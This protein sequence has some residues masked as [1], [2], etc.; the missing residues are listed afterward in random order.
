MKKIKRAGKKWQTEFQ[1]QD[2][3]DLFDEYGPTRGIYCGAMFSLGWFVEKIFRGQDG[4]PLQLEAFQLVILDT[5]WNKKFPMFLATRGGSKSFMIALYSVLRALLIPGSKVVIV[6]A[7]FRQAKTVFKYIE[8]FY[9][10]SPILR[11]AVAPWGGPKYGSDNASIR[12]GLSTIKAIPL[13]DGDKIRGERATVLIVDEF[14]SV[15]EEIFDIVL[16][17]FVSVQLNPAEKARIARFI[18]RLKELNVQQEILDLISSSQGFGNQVIVSGTPSYKHNHFYKRYQ[19]Y[20]MFINSK[21]D[22][23]ALKAAIEQ[24]ELSTTGKMKTTSA[25]DLEKMAKSH[26]NYAIIQLPY[27]ALPPEFLDEEMIRADRAAF[28]YHRF[29]MEYEAQF[30]DDSDGF[31][32]RS[33]IEDSTPKDNP[34]K[35]ELYGNPRATYVMGLDPARWNDNFGCVVLKITARGK[36]LVYCNAWD[37]TD[38]SKSAQK[39]REICMRFNVSYIAMDKGG[40]GDSVLEWL[41]TKNDTTTDNDIFLPIPDQTENLA[42]K[43]ANGRRIVE[44]VN[45]SPQWISEAAHSVEASIQQRNI[46]YPVTGDDIEIYDQYMRHFDKK[47]ISEKEKEMVEMDLWGLDEW[48]AERL[49]KKYNMKF[50]PSFGI[51]QHIEECKNE[52]CAIVR[53]VSPNGVEKFELPSLSHQPEGLD[54]RRRDRWSALMLANYAAKVY[55]GSHRKPLKVGQQPGQPVRGPQY[56]K[57]GFRRKGKAGW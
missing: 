19:I 30:P 3:L 7:G 53:N 23:K 40:G 9:E 37:R 20:Q 10:C 13:G 46:L 26:Q 47:D 42:M 16:K 48:D 32:K 4:K 2:I 36:E 54:M 38:F 5:L 34:V 55:M 50:E 15:P 56:T 44:L 57:H 11:E 33:W 8:T 17:P 39:I 12:I 6:G 29:R 35:I 18:K 52:T 28:P 24:N 43:S 51:W 25:D 1:Q 41:A 21:G 45:F 49:S 22:P 14:S 31:I 27:T